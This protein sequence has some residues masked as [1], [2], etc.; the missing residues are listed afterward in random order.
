[1]VTRLS[2]S[3]TSVVPR[4]K[5]SHSRYIPSLVFCSL[6]VVLTVPLPMP[7]TNKVT[8]WSSGTIQEVARS[9]PSN[10]TTSPSACTSAVAEPLVTLVPV[11]R[12]IAR[13]VAKPTIPCSLRV[14]PLLE[15]SHKPHIVSA[16]W[17][18]SMRVLVRVRFLL[19]AGMTCVRELISN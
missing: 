1:M 8:I 15:P 10:T 13:T 17:Q 4:G 3:P 14:P 9:S 2:E 6:A 12:M 7:Y 5:V 19:R 18:P 16:A 11:R